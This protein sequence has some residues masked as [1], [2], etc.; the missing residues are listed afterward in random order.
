MTKVTSLQTRTRNHSG[1]IRNAIYHADMLQL[2]EEYD[3]QVEQRLL[4]NL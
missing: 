2:G 3:L 4:H 1:M